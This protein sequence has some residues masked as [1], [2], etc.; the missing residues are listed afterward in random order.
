MIYTLTTWVMPLMLAIIVHEVAH[1]L[2]ARKLGDDTAYRAGRL[3]LNP[4]PHID[5]IG[6]ILLPILC[7]LSHSGIMFGW[8][9]PVPVNFNRLNHPKRDMGLVAGAGPLANLLLA[10]LLVIIGRFALEL[11][12]QGNFL[13]WLLLN[14][15]NG[16]GVSLVIGTFN[17]LP[18]LPLDGGRILV[19]ILPTK[20]A[21]KYQSTEKYGF[22]VLFGVILLSQISGINI[23]GW[24]IKTLW[25]LFAGIVELF[26]K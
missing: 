16:V 8:A 19:S 15:E 20:Y 14:I 3:T 9:K 25:P 13:K 17:L 7:W 2:I 23:I 22:F 24:F 6:S 26:M 18:I 1:G 4:L 10:I 11:L 21:I 5:P 12:P